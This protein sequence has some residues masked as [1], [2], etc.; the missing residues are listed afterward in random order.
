MPELPEVEVSRRGLLPHL[1]GQRIVDAVVRTQKLRHDIPPSLPTR[2]AGLRIDAILRRGKYLLFDCESAHG[3]GWLILH[4]GM[5]GSLRLVDAGTPPQ[6]HD[7]VD[8]I[9][10]HTTLR[11][12]DPR[13]FGALLWFEGADVAA[14]PALASLGI[15]PLT[16]QFDSDWLYAATRQ[17]SGPIKSVLMDSHLVVGIGNIYASESLFLAGVSPLR[18]ANRIGR[19]RYEVLVP[20]IRQTLETAI[21]AGGS[22]FRD[23]VHSD[24]GAGSFQLTCAVYDRDGKP[25]PKCARPLRTIR[26]AGRSTFYCASC[27]R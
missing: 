20:A 17:R 13:R 16:P 27:Q 19:A 18:A 24:G 14:H 1:C 8:L 6:K 5:S 3:G 9:F 4:L 25:C 22:S 10:V 23:Y 21:A 12:H 26:Q 2:L 7:H 15:E 11:L